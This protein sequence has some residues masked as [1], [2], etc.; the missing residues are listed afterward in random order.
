MLMKTIIPLFIEPIIQLIRIYVDKIDENNSL[1]HPVSERIGSP[2][3]LD[4]G[5]GSKLRIT[6]GSL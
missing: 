2:A 3:L 6:N 5:R 1:S 4:E